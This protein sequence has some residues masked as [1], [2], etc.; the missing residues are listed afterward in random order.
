M[1]ILPCAENFLHFD[2]V[3]HSASVRVGEE[4]KITAR[5]IDEPKTSSRQ[6]PR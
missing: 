4:I 2:V 6:S 1:D 5:D 3:F